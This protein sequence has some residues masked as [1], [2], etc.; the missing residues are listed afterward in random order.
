M[1]GEDRRLADLVREALP[2]T[3]APPP[4]C[5]LWPRLERRLE[6]ARPRVGHVDWLLAAVVV[7]LVAS[8]PE[9]ILVLLYHL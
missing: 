9:S 2:P 7:A 6:A 8:F 3:G 5:D 1:I 4:P